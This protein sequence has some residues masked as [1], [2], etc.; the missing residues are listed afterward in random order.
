VII[1]ALEGLDIPVYGDGL[2]IRDWLHVEDHCRGID[3][4]LSQG[5]LGETYNIGGGNEW[6]NIDIVRLICTRIDELRIGDTQ[7]ADLITFVEDRPGHDLRYA[8]DA[9]K[10]MSELGW[11][12]QRTFETGIGQTIDWYLDNSAWLGHVRDGAYRDYYQSQYADV[13]RSPS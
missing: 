10:I 4:V 2:N 9:G 12:P 13:A 6:Y 8:V 5:R 1:N 7:R 11:R 3:A